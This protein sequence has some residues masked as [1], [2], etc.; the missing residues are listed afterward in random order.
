MPLSSGARLGPYEIQSA[1]GAG[2]MGEVYKARDT[3]LGRTV[4]IKVLPAGL[5]AD[6]ARHARFEREARAIAALSHPHI[7]TLYDVGDYEGGMF[8]V[9]ELLDGET[10]A[11]RLRMGALPVDQVLT[12]AAQIADGLAAAHRQGV[13]HRD[14]KPG[15]VILTKSGAKILDFGLA[16][17]NA[18]TGPE[19]AAQSSLQT[20]DP[21]TGA[22]LLLG[23]VP[24]MSPEQLQGKDVDARSDVFSFGALLYEMLAGRRAFDADSHA[25]IVAAILEREPPSLSS[26]QPV[27][28]PGLDRLVRKCLA[29]D[30]EARWQAASDVADE[31]RWLSEGSGWGWGSGS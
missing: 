15:N 26:V 28:P 17:L 23:T 27:T 3:R 24:Y 21:V 2:G 11:A 10:L 13:I 14:L 4:A 9:M 7:C 12:I 19:P 30:P 5:S 16:K 25:G 18:A 8:L 1:I 20:Q 29:K 22:G 6:P 31:L